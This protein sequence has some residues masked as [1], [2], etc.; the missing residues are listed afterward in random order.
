[1]EVAG[2]TA[3][4]TAVGM[5][6]SVAT[7]AVVA[8]AVDST[9]SGEAVGVG[10]MGAGATVVAAVLQADKIQAADM[11][12]PINLKHILLVNIIHSLPCH[13]KDAF[14]LFIVSYSICAVNRSS[15]PS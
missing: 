7:G 14:H 1:M 6:V 8:V 15:P 2:A 10:G 13:M 12:I 5:G 3:V 11:V 9:G 4:A